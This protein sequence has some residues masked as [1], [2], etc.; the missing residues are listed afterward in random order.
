MADAPGGHH[1]S[2]KSIG[3]INESQSLCAGAA[4]TYETDGDIGSTLRNRNNDRAENRTD[5]RRSKCPSG[6]KTGAR[7]GALGANP[8][9]PRKHSRIQVRTVKVRVSNPRP[10]SGRQGG[11][12]SAFV[13]HLGG[14]R[15]GLVGHPRVGAGW[16]A[17]S[18]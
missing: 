11:A 13:T 5:E 6:R 2:G 12:R 3:R 17:L 16:S 8:R 4:P 18:P 15:S 7:F 9:N 1:G 14:L 10:P